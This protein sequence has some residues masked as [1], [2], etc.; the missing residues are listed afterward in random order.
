MKRIIYILLMMPCFIVA[1]NMYNVVPLVDKKLTGTARF[2]GMGGAMGALGGDIS[3][4]SSSPAGIALYRSNDAN[5]TVSADFDALKA[6]YNRDKANSDYTYAAIDNAG[7][8]L[9]NNIDDEYLKFINIGV[10]YR[11]CKGI[12]GNFEMYGIA[13]GFSQ[14]Y[15]IARLYSKSEFPIGNLNY[16][17][18]ENF[19]HS[20][21]ALLMAEGYY[22][23]YRQ[24]DDFITDARGFLLWEP[25]DIGYYSEERGGVDEV[26]IN[27]SANFADWLYLGATIGLSYVDYNRYSCYYENDAKGEIYSIA[28]NYSVK[29]NGINV[30]LGAIV[31]PFRYSP[32]KI[33][34][35]VHTPTWY[36]LTDRYSASIAAV[37][38]YI[39]DT[40]DEER[41]YDD[42]FLK[43]KFNTPWRFNTSVSYT[44]GTSLALCAEYEYADCSSSEFDNRTG[45]SRAQNEEIEK[46]LKEQHTFRL[47]AEYRLG[48]FSIRG[49][50]NFQS[51]PFSKNA[52]K[53]MDCANVTDTSTEYMNKFEKN[54]VT[55][56]A[57][58][59]YN[60]VY[61][62]VAY[63]MQTQK[64]DFYPFYD[65]EYVNPAAKV[66]ST[67]HSLVATL[68][69][70]F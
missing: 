45:A 28:N 43:Y 61:I 34:F 33:A 46:N 48:D 52:Y 56:G 47:G 55:L 20:W 17:M 15:E 64:A 66:R 38:G 36:E 11:R 40:R 62:D 1:Q 8:V 9:A 70:R 65:V 67:C 23:G 69:M 25:T 27:L 41:F 4:M 51:A 19:G 5:L 60:N 50:Y 57:G 53:D 49:G 18:Y 42:L 68:G 63:M 37:D 44:F 7:F 3:V 26:D 2:I 6:I 22:E 35:S 59:R 29:G 32:F 13:N 31:R 39:Y 16:K 30:K 21:L 14:Q 58:Y 12:E 10:A 24:G 54:V